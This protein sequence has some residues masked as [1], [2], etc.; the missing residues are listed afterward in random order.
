MDFDYLG[1]GT[2]CQ[3]QECKQLDFLPF[4]CSGCNKI[5]CGEHRQAKDHACSCPPTAAEEKTI[6]ICPVCARGVR[7]AEGLEADY[8]IDRHIQSGECDPQNYTRVHRKRRC[9][10][11]GCRE[12]LTTVNSYECPHCGTETCL[13]HRYNASD[14]ACT[15]RKSSSQSFAGSFMS[16]C[17]NMLSLPSTGTALIGSGNNK[18]GRGHGRQVREAAAC[19]HCDV[20]CQDAV[21]LVA[22]VEK[23]HAKV[24][25]K[26]PPQEDA[27]CVIM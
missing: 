13:K 23:R 24:S 16:T 26:H 10:V 11:K 8:L 19:P 3:F 1:I 21:Q 27:A 15:G 17:R 5:Y 2:N 6:V 18:A 12:R 7:V 20:V 25:G 9:P 22:H 14:H 4:R